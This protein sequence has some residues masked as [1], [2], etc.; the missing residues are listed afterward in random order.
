M[1]TPADTQGRAHTWLDRN[2]VAK[3][4]NGDQ[5]GFTVV[6][7]A[8]SGTALQDRWADVHAWAMVWRGTAT[9]LP[10]DARVDWVI[11]KLGPTRQELPHRLVLDTIAAVAAWAGGEYPSTL[12][13]A[14]SRWATLSAAFPATA[15]EKV[16]RAVMRWGQVD[17]DLLL[18]TARWF[19]DHPVPNDT[20]TPRQV[21]VP[22][23]HAKLLDAA[24]RRAVVEQLAGIEKVHLRNRPVQ[25]RVTY[26]D[27][28]HTDAGGRRWDLITADDNYQPPYDVHVVL[29][30]ENRDTAFY[31]PPQVPGG[32]L[33]LGNGDGAVSLLEAVLPSLGDPPLV[34]WGDIDAE[35][36]RIV[37]RL[38]F[39]GHQVTTVLMDIPTYDTYARF[40]T[41]R[42]KNGNTIPASRVLAPAG[43]TQDEV[44]LYTLLTSADFDGH[45][46]IEQERIPLEHALR[47]VIS[48]TPHPERPA[49]I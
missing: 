43:L 30:V 47:A 40:G 36:L 23:L 6:L 42:D 35:G 29:I 18:T 20:W 45:R 11:H 16:L 41:A 5:V 28:A 13:M 4:T 9:S 39:H 22:G 49:R 17:V 26:L 10:H 7:N 21:P 2:L 1:K 44:A 24:G 25:A 32:L 8:P 31:F 33:V 48:T 37:A 38:R 15:S 34:Y 3:V 19:A 14:R 27:P 12:A 46:R